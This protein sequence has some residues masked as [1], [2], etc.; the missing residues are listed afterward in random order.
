[1]IYI[2]RLLLILDIWQL[3]YKRIYN[4]SK[5]KLLKY[6]RRRNNS[7]IFV[8]N[9]DIPIFII[10]MFRYR[11][12]K[13]SVLLGLLLFRAS[14]RGWREHPELSNFTHPH[15]FRFL[16]AVCWC[17]AMRSYWKSD[18]LLTSATSR[19]LH[20]LHETN[21]MR[22]YGGWWKEVELTHKKQ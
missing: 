17:C 1:M 3:K 16:L 6:K 14:M 10:M 21:W 15:T 2:V 22:G 8:Q 18:M 12:Y 20:T 19:I 4:H 5:K 13:R 7:I 9:M 11:I